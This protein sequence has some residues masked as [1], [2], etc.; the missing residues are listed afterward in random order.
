[1]R[2]VRQAEEGKTGERASSRIGPG[3]RV[4]GRES[5]TRAWQVLPDPRG[6]SH[7][8]ERFLRL[9]G[10]LLPGP[11]R[12]RF[13]EAGS[14]SGHISLP[15]AGNS[16]GCFLVDYVLRALVLGRERFRAAGVEAAFIAADVR[17]LPFGGEIFDL[18]WNAGVLQTLPPEEQRALLAEMKRVTRPGGWV[19]AIVPRTEGALYRARRR[20]LEIRGRWPYGGFESPAA[21]IRASF[22]SCGL[23]GLRLEIFGPLDGLAEVR[24]LG[25]ALSFVLNRTP[26]GRPLERAVETLL[27]GRGYWALLAGRVRRE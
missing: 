24:V 14:G 23:E 26:L 19:A 17:A 9:L 20:R 4:T 1:V 3:S 7:T 27:P 11:G 6:W 21:E 15:L 8:D 22:E 12:G 25:R 13:L 2:G 10:G 5:W 16:R 18:T